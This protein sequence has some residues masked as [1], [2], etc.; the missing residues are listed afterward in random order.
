MAG[1]CHA[2]GE[3]IA[4]VTMAGAE[5]KIRPVDPVPDELG[6]IVAQRAGSRLIRG[7]LMPIGVPA[8][9]TRY[10]S[11]FETCSGLPKRK[12]PKPPPDVSVPLPF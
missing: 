8:Q 2:C 4:F 5:K 6:T 10:R 7:V 9:G 12:T 1:K 3:S 11:H